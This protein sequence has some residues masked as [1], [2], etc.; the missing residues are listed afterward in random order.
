MD[1]GIIT[2]TAIEALAWIGLGSVIVGASVMLAF[3][4]VWV[5][6]RYQGN[7]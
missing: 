4:V 6:D 3:L 7:R 2:F 5:T 1:W